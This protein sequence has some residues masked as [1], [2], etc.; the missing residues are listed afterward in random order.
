MVK[1][2]F[3]QANPLAVVSWPAPRKVSSIA[4]GSVSTRSQIVES[5][6]GR[7]T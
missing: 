3:T 5:R 2:Q 7:T 4:N 1:G 6:C